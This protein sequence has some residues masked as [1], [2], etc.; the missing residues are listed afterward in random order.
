MHGRRPAAF[1]LG[2]TTDA[3]TY[4]RYFDTPAVCYGPAARNIHGI[5]ESVDL[6]TI[7]DGARVLGRFLHDWFSKDER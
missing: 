3:R 4:V 1:S 5:D 2:S 7:R 6:P